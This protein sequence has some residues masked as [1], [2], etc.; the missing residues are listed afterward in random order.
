M[1][2]NVHVSTPNGSGRED[3]Q[4]VLQ[5]QCALYAKLCAITTLQQAYEQVKNDFESHHDG[6]VI[7]EAVE[8]QE[9]RN[10]LQQLSDDLRARTYRPSILSKLDLARGPFDRQNAGVVRD[11]VV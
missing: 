6:S 5:P 11:L 10:L 7:L 4:D 8:T 1:F 3:L 9:A 2:T